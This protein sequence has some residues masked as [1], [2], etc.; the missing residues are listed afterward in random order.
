MPDA[1]Q[2]HAVLTSLR[3]RLSARAGDEITVS[4]EDGLRE[5]I[6]NFKTADKADAS[7]FLKL[8]IRRGID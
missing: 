7:A 3:M 6:A 8:E 1:L 2:M 5:A 4:D